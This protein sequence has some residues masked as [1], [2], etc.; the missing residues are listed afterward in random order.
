MRPAVTMPNVSTTRGRQ[1]ATAAYRQLGEQ[2]TRDSTSG[3]DFLLQGLHHTLSQRQLTLTSFAYPK[4]LGG[5][6]EFVWLPLLLAE[7]LAQHQADVK[8]SALT[9][10]PI[11]IHTDSAAVTSVIKFFDH[12]GLG[13]TNFV[14]NVTRPEAWD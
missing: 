1:S 11:A 4:N 13:M 9:R 12:Y 2:P 14:Y 7:R 6:N 10:S 3:L 8:F 5:S